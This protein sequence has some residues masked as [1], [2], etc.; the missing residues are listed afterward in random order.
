MSGQ[1]IESNTFYDHEEVEGLGEKIGKKIV[2]I[3][4]DVHNFEVKRKSA[5][6]SK[7]VNA[8]LDSE[9][10]ATELPI[11]S[12]S[13]EILGL[14]VEYMNHHEGTEPPI[15]EKPLRYKNM[16]DVCRDNWDAVFIDRIGEDRQQLYDLILAANYMDIKSL[17]HLGCA[18]VASLIKG[19]PLE[20]IK[21]I[22]AT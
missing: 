1:T 6:I 13:S 22:L 21:D 5:C 12:V 4:K 10:G 20:K 16:V 18:K 17:L 19:E 8:S 14:I 9:E 2:L 11:P 3:S 15:I 7:L